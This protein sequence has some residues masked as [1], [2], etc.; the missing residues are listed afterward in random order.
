MLEITQKV[1]SRFKTKDV[2]IFFYPPYK[3]ALF[4]SLYR[5]KSSI[6][7]LRRTLPS[8][9]CESA[10]L[11]GTS[12]ITELWGSGYL[13]TLS[14]SNLALTQSPCLEKCSGQY[15]VGARG[16]WRISLCVALLPFFRCPHSPTHVRLRRASSLWTCEAAL[17]HTGLSLPCSSLSVTLCSGR[18]RRL[19]PYPCGLIF[20]TGAFSI[21]YLLPSWCS[22]WARS[23]TVQVPSEQPCLLDWLTKFLDRLVRTLTSVLEER[24]R[25]TLST[26]FFLQAKK[27]KIERFRD[28]EESAVSVLPGM[29]QQCVPDILWSDK[30]LQ[31]FCLLY[32][33]SVQISSKSVPQQYI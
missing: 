3:L 31:L 17:L 9:D 26:L 21:L 4:S 19:R 18:E 8:S 32:W 13:Q 27:K 15:L 7:S 20:S 16:I 23:C 30:V 2:S 14:A 6:W 33:H 1:N 28:F 12:D 29:W 22:R 11:V 10:A 5:I 24:G 25:D